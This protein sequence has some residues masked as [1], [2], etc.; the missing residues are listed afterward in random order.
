MIFNVLSKAIFNTTSSR[1]RY[2]AC[3]VVL[4][5][6]GLAAAAGNA[7]AQVSELYSFQFDSASSSF[8]DGQQP[9]SELIQGADGDYYTTISFGGAGTC[10]G[11]IGGV[12]LGCGAVVKITPAGT[13][14]LVYSFPFDSGTQVAPD[15]VDPLAGL[16]QGPDR[17]FYGTTGWG[18][19]NGNCALPFVTSV[20]CGTAFRLTPA[21]KLKVLHSFCGIDG[22]GALSVD[23]WLPMGRLIFGSDGNLYGTTNQGGN[24]GNI[25]NS[26]TIFKISRSGAYKILHMFSGNGGTGDGANPAA[27]LIQAS[28]GNFYGTTQAGGVDGA[29]TVFMMKSSGAVI[30]LH[31][32]STSDGN[33]TYPQSALVE[34]SDGNLYGTCYSGGANSVGTVFRISKSGSFQKIYDFT[35][36]SGNDGYA[37]KAGLILASDGNLYGTTWAG[38]SNF[39]DSGTLYQVTTSGAVTL[40]ANFDAN[41]TGF[42]PLDVP[43]Q[44]S[45]GNLYVTLVYGGG[46]NPQGVQN[47]GAID[48]FTTGFVPLPPSIA[49]FSPSK[50]RVGAKVTISGSSFVG[51]T[52]V[53]F[54][55]THASFTVEASGFIVAKVPAG[56]SSGPIT[57]TTPGGTTASKTSFTVL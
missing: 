3:F 13:F 9:A 47:Q 44:G 29:G 15:G 30:V 32:F 2:L 25:F 51:A 43:L 41:T 40:L 39:G 28:D 17:N 46:Q 24:G 1:P 42:Q 14:S 16:V 22:C 26:G 5:I 6:L 35:N 31:S 45:D 52:S 37:P 34:G 19:T 8:P 27:G 21:G 53:S 23:G 54:N 38:G 20:G 4:L 56:A 48:R 33:G 11:G 36:A 49:S 10:P 57:V 7:D 12:T 18:G 55:G 50:G